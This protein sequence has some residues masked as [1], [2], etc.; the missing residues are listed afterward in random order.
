MSIFDFQEHFI[1]ASCLQSECLQSECEVYKA[2][3]RMQT[4]MVV[5]VVAVVLTVVVVV[6]VIEKIKTIFNIELKHQ[7]QACK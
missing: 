6:V 3:E 5:V 1:K 4:M 2:T 7:L